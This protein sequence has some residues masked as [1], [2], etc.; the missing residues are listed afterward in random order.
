MAF[1]MKS[2]QQIFDSVRHSLERANGTIPKVQRR[3]ERRM[4]TDD[5]CCFQNPCIVSSRVVDALHRCLSKSGSLTNDGIITRTLFETFATTR[6]EEGFPQ[7]K[8]RHSAS[9]QAFLKS[10]G[11]SDCSGAYDEAEAKGLTWVSQETR[12]ARKY[13]FSLHSL[14]CRRAPSPLLDVTSAAQIYHLMDPC[15][16]HG[17]W[18]LQLFD[19]C[20]SICSLPSRR[21]PS[22]SVGF[23]FERPSIT[24]DRAPFSRQSADVSC[25][26][27]CITSTRHALYA[28][29]SPSSRACDCFHGS[30]DA[31]LD[32]ELVG[33]LPLDVRQLNSVLLFCITSPRFHITN[34]VSKV[35][36]PL[37]VI[38]H[39]ISTAFYTLS[40]CSLHPRS[41]SLCIYPHTQLTCMSANFTQCSLDFTTG[42]STLE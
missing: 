18:F 42:T 6:E 22:S 38:S 30:C 5:R 35:P 25:R 4:H 12:F 34:A 40:T 11:A 27:I 14:C 26:V 37:A 39:S 28:T 24:E 8:V 29:L 41:L 20:L 1:G 17:G 31:I 15:P 36:T 21:L 2:L 16:L 19:Y 7:P 13:R 32:H 10:H 9:S 33:F 3:G 23:R